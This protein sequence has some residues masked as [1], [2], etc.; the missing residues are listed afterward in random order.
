MPDI[1]IVIPEVCAPPSQGGNAAPRFK[2]AK[3]GLGFQQFDGGTD[4]DPIGMQQQ[5]QQDL[6]LNL[7][8]RMIFVLS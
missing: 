2:V 3:P 1:W 4:L 8:Y 5:A 6:A 7:C